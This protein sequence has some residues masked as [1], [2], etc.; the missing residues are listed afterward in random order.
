M[1]EDCFTS[2]L[3]RP[4]KGFS[5]TGIYIFNTAHP[6]AEEYF[7][8]WQEYYDKDKLFN[9]KGY[10]DSFVF[11]AVRIE[12]E[13]EGNKQ[14][15]FKSAL[16]KEPSTKIDWNVLVEKTKKLVRDTWPAEVANE[17]IDRYCT[18]TEVI[19]PFTHEKT[20]LGQDAP[21]VPEKKGGDDY[22]SWLE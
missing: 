12:M 9:L 15:F 16:V 2:Y 5:E 7:T 18:E 13:E 8:R 1:P 19:N 3:G 10:T 17:Y 4:K 11:D 6:Y 21:L 14:V 20:I 22:G